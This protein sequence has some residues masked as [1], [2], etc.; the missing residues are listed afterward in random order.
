MRLLDF[1]IKVSLTTLCTRIVREKSLRVFLIATHYFSA[2]KIYLSFDKLTLDIC[3]YYQLA[4]NQ[5]FFILQLY[6]GSKNDG[7]YYASNYVRKKRNIGCE[8]ATTIYGQ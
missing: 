1:L 8:V 4:N 7:I 3:I 6:R 2:I 5:T